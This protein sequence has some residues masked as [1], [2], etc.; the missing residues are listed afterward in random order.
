MWVS[1]SLYGAAK[2]YT[3]GALLL[4][5]T[6]ASMPHLP[7]ELH[8]CHDHSTPRAVLDSLAVGGAAM[9][10]MSSLGV[11]KELR[12][13]WRLMLA[14]R[15]PAVL[16]LDVD[17]AAGAG[18]TL[19]EYVPRLVSMVGAGRAAMF[20]RKANYTYG[21][22]AVEFMGCE[23]A[24][25]GLAGVLD[26]EAL[27]LRFMETARPLVFEDAEAD[28][29]SKKRA[30]EFYGNDEVFLAS[31]AN[32]ARAAG[33]EVFV[34]D[35]GFRSRASKRPRRSCTER[36][37]ANMAACMMALSG[38]ACGVVNTAPP[39]NAMA[40]SLA[41]RGFAELPDVVLAGAARAWWESQLARQRGGARWDAYRGGRRALSVNVDSIPG[42]AWC[43]LIRPDVLEALQW[44]LG[45][46]DVRVRDVEVIAV[47]PR[48][49]AQELHRDHPCGSRTSLA[50]AVSLGAQPLRTLV[51]A[52]SHERVTEAAPAEVT[53]K[54]LLF[55]GA[56][57]HGGGAWDGA[58]EDDERIFVTLERGDAAGIMRAHMDEE[59]TSKRRLRV[60]RTLDSLL[61][62]AMTR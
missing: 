13:F 25:V 37:L 24:F 60:A 48:S 51:V 20:G 40:D 47:Q 39:P 6:I 23:V 2:K 29:S 15:H 62:H 8:V 14:S 18:I 50:L 54:T 46:R 49:G 22:H 27:A 17:D 44:Y 12:M 28:P 38:S 59:G 34:H 4:Q 45:T 55:D 52:G 56:L 42:H 32:E 33:V 35:Q 58:L 53:S 30:R 5:R 41:V 31:L 16:V 3:D 21:A 61:V 1:V 57:M 10:D 36:T 43:A 9:H 11:T 7:V 26:A 19:E